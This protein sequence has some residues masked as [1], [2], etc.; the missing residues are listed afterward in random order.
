MWKKKKF[1]NSFFQMKNQT[2]DRHM[3]GFGIHT[4]KW[5]NEEGKIFWVK[6]HFKSFCKQKPYYKSSSILF[7]LFRLCVA[8]VQSLTQQEADNLLSESPHSATKDLFEAIAKGEN[9]SWRMMAQI[10][11]EE[12]AANYK[13]DI[14]DTTKVWP[15]KDY[16]LMEIGRLVLNRNPD[17]YFNEVEQSAFCPGRMVPGFEPSP[18]PM[19]Q[20]RIFAYSDAQRYRLS[21]NFEQIPINCAHGVMKAK[22]RS[23]LNESRDGLMSV[24]GTS[25]TLPNYFPNSMGENPAPYLP[26]KEAPYKLTGIVGRH[27]QPISDDDFVQPSLQKKKKKKRNFFLQIFFFFASGALW[28][29]V[30]DERQK[31]RFIA[32]VVNHLSCCKRTDIVERVILNF[33]MIDAN[34]A[35]R[36]A[37]D[38]GME[39]DI[40]KKAPK[41]FEHPGQSSTAA[42]KIRGHPKHSMTSLQIKKH[43]ATGESIKGGDLEQRGKSPVPKESE[44]MEAPLNLGLSSAS[45]DLR[46]QLEQRETEISSEERSERG[47]SPIMQEKKRLESPSVESVINKEGKMG[48]IG[49]TLEPKSKEERGKSP[50]VSSEIKKEGLV[51]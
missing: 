37:S 22:Q 21:G 31:H 19:L 14:F 30:F 13:I 36:I 10:M 6:I 46:K 24:K 25:G 27:V 7:L 41:I 23:M 17:N 45:T 42:H 2:L 35:K 4:F 34:L 1:E 3:D 12:E 49:L 32:N 40:A 15:Y 39:E 48:K 50:T 9:P 20:A 51:E 29:K 47:K 5:V 11:P 38:L 28:H 33:H 43:L 8:G 18:D 26:A 44:K 16:P